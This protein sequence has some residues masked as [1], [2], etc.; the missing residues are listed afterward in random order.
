MDI[1]N[2]PKGSKV[3][4]RNPINNLLCE[5]TKIHTGNWVPSNQLTESSE[6]E[7]FR[8]LQYKDSEIADNIEQIL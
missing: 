6:Y 7:T 4:V 8:L 3:V 2:L 5:F 1:S